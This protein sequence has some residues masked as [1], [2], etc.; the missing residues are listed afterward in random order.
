MWQ[1]AQLTEGVGEFDLAVEMR[2]VLAE[3]KRL[4]IGR[5][6]PERIE[7]GG[8]NRLLVFDTVFH[9]INVPFDEPGLYEFCVMAN[10]VELQGPTAVLRVLDLGEK[11]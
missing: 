7:F 6:Q 5:S 8:G 10:Y 1:Y 2:R 4:T 11:L 9:M 3:D